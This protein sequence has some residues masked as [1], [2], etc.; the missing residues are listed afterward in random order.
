MLILDPGENKD[1]DLNAN[2]YDQL[3]PY[4]ADHKKREKKKTRKK[5]P[6]GSEE[7]GQS[8]K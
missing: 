3:R 2:P 6:S 1:S 4:T 7:S 5:V 8:H